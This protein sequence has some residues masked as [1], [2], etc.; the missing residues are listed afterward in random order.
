MSISSY[1]KVA[2]RDCSE[3]G[4]YRGFMEKKGHPVVCLSCS[5]RGGTLVPKY[6]GRKFLGGVK[7]IAFRGSKLFIDGA[8]SERI[9]YEQFEKKVKPL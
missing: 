9:T 4:L 6:T 7:S 1:V 8:E 3:T 2:C 5:G